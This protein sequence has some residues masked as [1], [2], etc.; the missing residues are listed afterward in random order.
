MR[1]ARLT[2]VPLAVAALALPLAGCGK[3]KPKMPSSDARQ[4]IALLEEAKRRAAAHACRDLTVENNPTLPALQRQVASLPS[5][6]DS[7]IRSTLEDGVANLRQLVAAECSTQQQKPE[8]PTTES[9]TTEPST[10]TQTQT[11]TTTQSTQTQ[12][13]TNSQPTTNTQPQ[14][15]TGPSGGVPPGQQKKSGSKGKAK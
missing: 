10:Q 9:T 11:H 3:D 6:V 13:T 2:A 12:P 5:N 4:L 8:Q 14:D 15:N 1:A 7:D